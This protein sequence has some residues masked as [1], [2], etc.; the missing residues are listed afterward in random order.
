MLLTITQFREAVRS[1]LSA[2]V[3][4]L[5]SSTGRGGDEEQKAWESSLPALADV[6]AAPEFGS[7]HMY[8]GGHGCL[9]LEYQLPAASSWC[10]VVLLGRGSVTPSVVIVELKH[11]ITRGDRPGPAE[12]LMERAGSI[13]LHPADQVRGYSEYCRRFHSTVQDQGADVRGCVLF[14]RDYYNQAYAE[15]PN[16]TLVRDYPC[17]TLSRHVVREA[18]PAYLARTLNSPDESFAQAFI[19]GRYRQD[20]GFVR[21]IGAQ[22]R[23]RENSPFELLDH[24]RRAFSLVRARLESEVLGRGSPRKQVI[25]I[26]GPPGSGKSVVA[27]RIWAALVTDERL[28][29]GAAVLTT[30]STAQTSNWA[31]LFQI[32]GDAHAAAGVVKRAASYVPLTTQSLGRL[33]HRHGANFANDATAWRD[34]VQLLRAWGVPF[35]DGACDE[36]YLVSVV[37]EAH[38]LIN[39]EHSEGRGQFGFAP[40]FGP[41]AYHIIRCS[42]VSIFLLDAEQSFRDRENTTLI[43]IQRWASELGAEVAEPISLE[44]AQFRCAGSTDYVAWLE[45]LLRGEPAEQLAALAQRWRGVFDVQLADTL[46][47]LEQ[48][49]RDRAGAG[50]T[51]RLLASYARKWNTKHAA[52]PHALPA[53]QQDFH[54]PY[55]DALGTPRHWSKVWNYIPRGTDYTWFIQAPP[56]S[57][58]HADPLCEVG[59]PYVVRGFD[60]DAV[61]VLWLADLVWRGGHWRADP[62]Y[63]HDTGLNR[64]VR[65]AR[66]ERT[67]GPAHETLSARLA[68]AYRILLTRGMS[69]CYL[70]IEDAETRA[71][72]RTCLGI[73]RD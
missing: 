5:Q 30:T 69:G 22:I 65:A 11:W 12:G 23:D 28:P 15:P 68:Q 48:R 36:Q 71:H 52:R 46:A 50:R 59:C 66:H 53:A 54:E 19:A 35:Q 44:G 55:L 38:A 43:D 10:D 31:Q 9:A 42:T 32:A 4:D 39:P 16:D 70:W 7:L 27:A 1:D 49:L 2:L 64:S 34:N 24:Q 60:F 8:L 13:V 72:L 67:P 25:V 20:R 14:T 56:G 29:D 63:V 26:Q 62:S 58:M 6:L 17:F 41:L 61:G 47:E 3:A 57:P 37:D 40:T 33:R 21:Q 18:W 45:G 73:A 51:V